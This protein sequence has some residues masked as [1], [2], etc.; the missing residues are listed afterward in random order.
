MFLDM[1]KKAIS[2]LLKKPIMLWGLTLLNGFIGIVATLAT[3]TVPVVSIA[4]SY[5]L[6]C[7][8]AKVFLDGL[9]GKEVNSDQLFAAFNK[10]CLRT[11]GGMAW[12]T[13]WVLIWCL[14][15]I[16]GPVIAVIK[17]YSYSFVPYILMTKPEVN[18]TAA[19]RLSKKMTEGKKGQMFLADLCIYGSLAIVYLMLFAF[20]QIPFIGML[21]TLLMLLVSIVVALF[22]SI[23]VG[24]YRAA[25]YVSPACDSVE[26]VLPENL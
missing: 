5:L 19:L 17:S 13:L 20:S 21:F 14:I 9:Y 16:A 24:L 8:M 22:L 4:V 12:K 2:V 26:R 6:T 23:F 7:G 11:A 18:A 25:F 15:P 10:N 3:I 1:Y